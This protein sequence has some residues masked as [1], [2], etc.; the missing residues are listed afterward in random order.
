VT[1]T[2][3]APR[4]SLERLGERHLGE[5]EALAHD[6]DV[7]RFTRV[8][9]PPP[10]GFAT[11]WLA[12]YLAGAQDGTCAGFA[13]YGPAGEFVGIGVAPAIDPEARELELGYVIAAA[14]RGR[15]YAGA[16]LQAMTHWAL[17]EAGA[18]RI[19]LHIDVANTASIRVAERGGYTREGVMRSAH[20]KQGLRADTV[21]F[22]LLP[23]DPL[24]M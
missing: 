21:L 22:S 7:R 6:P 8:P 19:V 17:D 4:I 11:T 20:V 16:V 23:S 15:G 24:P 10:A 13:A 12:H 14:E 18:Q 1:V 2:E 9:D 5:L 3:R